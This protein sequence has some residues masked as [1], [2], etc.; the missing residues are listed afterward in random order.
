MNS[1][2]YVGTVAGISSYTDEQVVAVV[3]IGARKSGSSTLYPA[4]YDGTY[5]RCEAVSGAVLY[6]YIFHY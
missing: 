5:I 1:A 2:S 3:P 6:V 4:I